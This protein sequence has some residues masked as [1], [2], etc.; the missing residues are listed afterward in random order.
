M[1]YSQSKIFDELGAIKK[2]DI[3]PAQAQHAITL[4]LAMQPH[5]VTRLSI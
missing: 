4:F 1:S 2:Q 3:N 5:K